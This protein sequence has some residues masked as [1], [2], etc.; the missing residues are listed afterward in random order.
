[1]RIEKSKGHKI[2]CGHIYPVNEIVLGSKWMGSSGGI[3]TVIK[4]ENDQVTYT[5]REGEDQKKVRHDKDS[6]SFQCRY[7]LIVD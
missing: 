5:W 7:C 6:F 3:V 1:M 2:V 4:I